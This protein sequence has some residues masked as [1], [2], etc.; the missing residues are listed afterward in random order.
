MVTVVT[1]M[2]QTYTTTQQS[3]FQQACLLPWLQA[4]LITLEAVAGIST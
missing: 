2:A 4:I 3:L 1:I